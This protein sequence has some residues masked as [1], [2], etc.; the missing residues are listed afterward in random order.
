MLINL[1]LSAK[2]VSSTDE[3]HASFIKD[4]NKAYIQGMVSKSV[5][6][7]AS[8]YDQKI[9]LLTEFQKT[10][11]GKENAL[12]YFKTLFS[13]VDVVS[14]VRTETE[15]LDLG[16]GVLE[17]GV[18]TMVVK[19]NGTNKEYQLEGKYQDIW[20]KS[21]NQLLLTAMAW[22]YNHQVEIAEQLRLQNVP[23]VQ[24][25]YASHTPINNPVSFQLAALCRLL[26]KT[27]SE[28]DAKIW[29]QFYAD[30][31]KIFTTAH[32]TVEGRK[33]IDDYLEIHVKELP[34]FEK[35][36]VRNDQIDDLGGYVIEYASHVANWRNGESSGV[37][38]GKNIRIWR[39]E[40]DGSLKIFRQIGMY[41]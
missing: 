29:S 26:E 18:F 20:K 37:N 34:V 32:S 38:T 23:E 3:G 9:R 12:L 30:D 1:S 10:I 33:A 13:K 5:K 7:T 2:I 17:D 25:A 8:Y 16:E 19:P 24:T 22:N 15:V 4:F 41:D 39:R 40:K 31:C 6:S 35:L 27:I 21:G 36:D 11:I 14:F 28:H